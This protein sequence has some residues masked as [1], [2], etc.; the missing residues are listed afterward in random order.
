MD[1]A[2]IFKMFEPL[3]VDL[4][5]GD[6]FHAEKP[7]LAHY[8]SIPVLEAI[9][10][11]N[12]IWFS[13]PLFMNDIEE[14]RFGVH[15]GAILFL[16]SAEIESACDNKERFDRLK[17]TFKHYY[18]KFLNEHVIDTYVFCLSEHVKDG[19]DGLLSMWRGYG[20]N[21]NGAAIV[22]DSGRFPVRKGSP[23]II[24]RVQYASTEERTNWLQQRTTQ[25]AEILRQ[26]RLPDDKLYLGSYYFFERLKLF[27]VF[28]KR[29]G[30]KEESEWRVVYMKDRD[31]DKAFDRMF[32]YWVG[33]RGV[34][35]KLKLKVEHI[36]GLTEVDVSLSKIIERI[37]LGPS[38]SSPLA[39]ASIRKMLD[40]LGRSDLTDR[41]KSSTI[42]L[43]AG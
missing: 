10:R 33:P 8:T 24:A 43:R 17:A 6:S 39:R 16:T 15:V 21:G 4:L 28:T 18:N 42:P 32:S 23:L 35:P 29:Q 11:N 40:T 13:N 7:L 9:L 37:I 34:E 31:K 19:T 20:G 5:E 41:I 25:F 12:E 30:F 38:L 27:V 36:P 22:F 2:Q 14:L 1:D 3:F 26:S